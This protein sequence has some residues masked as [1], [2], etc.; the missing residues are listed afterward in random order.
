VI[1]TPFLEYGLI[2]LEANA[3]GTPVIAYGKGGIRET[4][5]PAN[6]EGADPHN[7]TAV[8]FDEQ[9]A[10]AVIEAVHVFERLR[11]D[12]HALVRHASKWGVPEFQAKL[13][14]AVGLGQG[15]HAT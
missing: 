7:A 9:T 1:F 6:G 2:P 12:A 13:R 3:S 5:I 10:E 14:Q 8:F 11:F 15:R 4:M